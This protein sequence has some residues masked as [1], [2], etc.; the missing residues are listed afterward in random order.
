MQQA[1]PMDG[2]HSAGDLLC[3]GGGGHCGQGPVESVF[4]TPARYVFEHQEEATICFA[5]VVNLHPITNK[6]SSITWS[7]LWPATETGPI[8]PMSRFSNIRVLYASG[9]QAGMADR[10]SSSDRGASQLGVDSDPAHHL[11]CRR[12][13]SL[14]NYH[15]AA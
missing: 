5:H 15:I 6:G 11:K 10:A 2:G 3:Q 4:Q 9:T 8:N 7:S 1:G 13:I 12:G 14:A